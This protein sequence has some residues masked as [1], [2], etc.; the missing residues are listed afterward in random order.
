[1]EVYQFDVKLAFL[2]EDLQEEVYVTQ[3][4]VSQKKAMKE[5]CTS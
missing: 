5:W 3:L 4:K 2:N 1:M